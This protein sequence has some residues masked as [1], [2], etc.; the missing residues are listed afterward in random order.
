MTKQSARDACGRVFVPALLSRNR[1]CGAANRQ[2]R[3]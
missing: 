2:S 3:S 1:M